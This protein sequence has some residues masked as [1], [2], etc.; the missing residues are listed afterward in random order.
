M[1]PINEIE[2]HGDAV[3]AEITQEVSNRMFRAGVIILG[4][5]QKSMARP[6]SGKERMHKR[7]KSGRVSKGQFSRWQ[8]TRRSAPGEP[9]A[10]QSGLLQSSLSFMEGGLQKLS[11]LRWRVGTTKKY[12]KYLEPPP[13]AP[14]PKT[15]MRPRPFLQPAVDKMKP[16][17]ERLF[18][19][20]KL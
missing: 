9:P 16:K 10:V 12:A 13:G 6:K 11:A 1:T 20:E 4:E 19:R 5:A 2:W 14:S 17:I 15:R 7:L 3:T 8:Q 18:A